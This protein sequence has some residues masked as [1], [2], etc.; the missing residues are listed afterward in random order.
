MGARFHHARPLHWAITG[1]GPTWIRALAGC[2]I[3]TSLS[4]SSCSLFTSSSCSSKLL[5]LK[6]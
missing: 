2:F 3:S 6:C 4:P 5:F 1:A